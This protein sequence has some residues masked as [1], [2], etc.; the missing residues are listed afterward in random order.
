LLIAFCFGFMVKKSFD[1]CFLFWF[2]G[3]NPLMLVIG[4]CFMAKT[5]ANCPC[6]D[7]LQ[8][9]STEEPKLRS[10]LLYRRA[11]ASF[12]KANMPGV[13]NLNDLLQ[14][15]AKD[16]LTLL[17]FDPKN[18]E[19]TT[20]L[21]SIRAQHAI[22]K[23]SSTPVSGTFDSIKELEGNDADRIHKL[24]ILSG[25]MDNDTAGASME[26]GRLGGVPYL[27]GLADKEK[28]G[29]NEE[30]RAL[31]LNCLSI[32]GGHPPFVRAYYK[33]I[34]RQVLEVIKKDEFTD[35]VVGGLAILAKCVLHLDRDHPDKPVSEK[36]DVDD[37]ALVDACIAVMDASGADANMSV[38]GVMENL[39]VWASGNDRTFIIRT[40][41][42]G[43]VTNTGTLDGIPP[44]VSKAEKDAMTPKQLASHR[45]RE[46][47]TR[48]R[49]EKWHLERAKLF[50]D[51][52]GLE[53]LLRCATSLND[54]FLR[55]ELTVVLGKIL[56]GFQDEERVK[57]LCKP[58]LTGQQDKKLDEDGMCTIEEVYNEDE[59]EANKP[60]AEEEEVVTLQS[61]MERAELSTALLL[62]MKEVGAWA[63]CNA[64]MDSDSEL[65]QMVQS[66][67][68]RAMALASEL[69]SAA[70][71]VPES[72]NMVTMLL[73]S[74]SM[75]KL[76]VHEDRDIRSGVAAAVAKLGLAGRDRAQAD[77]GDLVAMLQAAADLLDDERDQLEDTQPKKGDEKKANLTAS[78][79]TSFGTTSLERG[80]EM[81]TYLIS[82]TPAKEE[83]AGGFR[84]R[85]DAKF[86]VL[87]NLVKVAE[88]PKAGESLC[89]FGLATI[90]QHMAVTPHQLKKEH[91]A[92]KELSADDYDELQKMAKTE[93]EKKMFEAMKSDDTDELCAERIRMMA[94]ANVPRALVLLMEGASEH[95]LEQIVV[96]LNRMAVEPSVRGPMI[97]Q[98]ALTACIKV[99]N[100]PNPS[101]LMKKI[102]R[103]ARHCIARMLITMN[104]SLLT[105]AQCMG[106]IKPLIQ[107]IRD[108]ETHDLLRFEAL[109][110]L[111]NIGASGEDK[112]NK[113][114]AERGIPT[115]NYAMFSE[116]EQI[117][118]AAT[119][120]MCNLVG[121]RDFMEYLANPENL[122]LWLAFSADC[123]ENYEC[124]R[125]ASGCLAMATQDPVI[126]VALAKLPN[127][128][129]H[130]DSMLQCGA[131][132]IMHR[133]FVLISNLVAH[134][135]ETRE[136]VVKGG[137]ATF[138][139]KYVETYHDGSAMEDIEFPEEEKHLM[140]ITVDLAK[141]IVAMTNE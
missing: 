16:L 33:D 117:R 70:A 54:H 131:L 96:A 130:V 105:S 49:N 115:F 59:E 127:F 57:K 100:D 84:S 13:T 35:V 110:A 43:D 98:G 29:A 61:M 97:Q 139:L 6:F 21:Q 45:Q 113:I 12:L 56:S 106:A 128:Q 114:V 26:L 136:A 30:I 68:N 92:D 78:M 41:I 67:D 108:V 137:F 93:E 55:R 111:T 60:P 31:S 135:G 123:E 39:T 10:K 116:H 69:I 107:L 90:F 109:M 9:S 82:Q 5:R 104:P 32:A 20:L 48:K 140:P 77:E 119:E 80:V 18:K 76:L 52:G 79:A 24:K 11:K 138:C 28:S 7:L 44:P 71:T 37:N 126:A 36:S 133:V 122:R 75:E 66:D 87:E 132:Q 58:Y 50:C 34:Q 121:Q 72:R 81:I 73:D 38:R 91:F 17:S 88:T 63:V 134:G 125:A 25:L 62:S 94:K 120:A 14:G 129:K 47:D 89:G 27:L 86:T 85:I 4:L 19:A 1:D 53:S 103:S 42:A 118:K 22:V 83:I 3:Q 8:K 95:T 46:A 64:W 99:D 23:K 112:K 15:A 124:A 141:K 2:Y 74:G 40:A 101:N 51:K 102:H 65:S